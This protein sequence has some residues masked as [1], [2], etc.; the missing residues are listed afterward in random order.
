MIVR[1]W[2]ETAPQ[3]D[4]RKPLTTMDELKRFLL[5]SQAFVISVWKEET[6]VGHV[7]VGLPQLLEMV[8]LQLDGESNQLIHAA[9][10]TGK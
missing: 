8:K 6:T 2:K 1:A 9:D 10:I 4:H 3:Q 7:K 5:A